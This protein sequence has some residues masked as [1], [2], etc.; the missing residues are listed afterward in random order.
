[1]PPAFL[2]AALNDK[3]VDPERNT[4]AMAG[5]LKGAGVPVTLKLYEN[6]DHVL[7]AAS[8]AWSLRWMSPVLDDVAGFVKQEAPAN[9]AAQR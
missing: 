5:K 2:G 7:L 4:V 3:L 8:M 9:Q 1:M 6:I